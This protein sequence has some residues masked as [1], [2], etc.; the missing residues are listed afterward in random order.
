MPLTDKGQ[1]IMKAMKAQ[2]GAKKGEQVF[3]ASKNAGKISGV[4][5]RQRLAESAQRLRE[6]MFPHLRRRR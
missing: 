3:Y 6:S 4:E 5:S 2:Y 1:K